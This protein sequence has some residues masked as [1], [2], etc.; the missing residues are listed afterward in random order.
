[1]H[2]TVPMNHQS[3]RLTD[4]SILQ[5]KGAYL[6]KIYPAVVSGSLIPLDQDE[7]VF[8]RDSIC[9]Y[10][11]ADDFSSRRHI[12]IRWERNDCVLRDLGS[13]NGTFV[14]DMRTTFHKLKHGDKIHFGTQIFKFLDSENV[15]AT[16]HEAVFQMMTVD[17]LTQTY[18]RR[19]FEDVFQREASRSVRHQRS[20]GLLILD[21]DKFKA[22]NDTYGHLVGDEV[23]AAVSKRISS[24]IRKDDVLA[25]IGGEEFAVTLTEGTKESL[26]LVGHQL[27]QIVEE[28]PFRTSK[29]V[30]PVTISV[31]GAYVNGRENFECQKLFEL[32]DANLYDAKM[33]GRN[34][35]VGQRP[36][37]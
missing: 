33:N 27:C 32:A 20:L 22:I 13:T 2:S 14:N 9:D 36:I 5:E 18:N 28:S 34:R 35:Y 12:S 7:T 11:V 3:Q 17:A 31:G 26:D 24:R 37:L 30:V 4:S 25:R 21:I 16:Y 15:E 8:G 19:Y 23:L 6:V 29:G 10:E 1:M